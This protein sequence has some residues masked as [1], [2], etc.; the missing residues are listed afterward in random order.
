MRLIFSFFLLVAGFTHVFAQGNYSFSQNETPRMSDTPMLNYIYRLKDELRE[1]QKQKEDL[2]RSVSNYSSQ[3]DLEKKKG[4]RNEKKIKDL[5]GWLNEANESLLKLNGVYSIKQDSLQNTLLKID[6][7]K[8][9]NKALL[10]IVSDYQ[11]ESDKHA[12]S[13]NELQR[14]AEL[15]GLML[16]GFTVFELGL[17]NNGKLEVYKRYDSSGVTPKDQE[18]FLNG[19]DLVLGNI[20]KLVKFGKLDVLNYSGTLCVPKNKS[21]GQYIPGEVL[22][23][24]NDKLAYR[25]KDELKLK[26]DNSISN[27]QCYE[28]SSRR[29]VNFNFPSKAKIRIGF[30]SEET[31]RHLKSDDFDNFWESDDKGYFLISS[32]KST[33]KLNSFSDSLL[34]KNSVVLDSVIVKGSE[35]YIDIYDNNVVDGDIASF[36]VNGILVID[37]LPLKNTRERRLITLS[38]D[39]NTFTLVANSQGDTPPCTA[40]VVIFDSTGERGAITLSGTEKTSHSIKII[41]STSPTAKSKH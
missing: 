1:K 11:R 28:I 21:L 20:N 14:D 25:L 16:S 18:V 3:I 7:L 2:K 8:T 19:S 26:S 22:I 10:K 27:I 24:V 30:V 5:Y 33:Y 37:K 32:L 6:T 31:L 23:Y 39:I 13:V 9:K 4:E 35:I 29:K 40:H 36:Y 41:R 12:V 38:A 34:I 17:T 15:L